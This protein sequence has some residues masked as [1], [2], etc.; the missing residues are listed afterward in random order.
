MISHTIQIGNNMH[1]IAHDIEHFCIQFAE[2][3]LK[4][5]A[6]D[7]ATDPEHINNYRLKVLNKVIENQGIHFIIIYFP[8]NQKNV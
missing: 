4:K 5:E 8:Y 2:K 1:L 3:F 7:V 6:I